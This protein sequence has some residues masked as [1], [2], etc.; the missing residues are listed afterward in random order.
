MQFTIILTV[1]NT[2][3]YLN[4]CLESID[5]QTYRDFE[6]LI[7]DDGSTDSSPEICDRFCKEKS[8][9]R[10]I[11]KDNEGLSSA[12]NLGIKESKGKYLV[13]ID[14]DDLIT[15]NAL[16][17]INQAMNGDEDIII[18]ELLNCFEFPSCDISQQLYNIPNCLSVDE[19]IDYVFHKENVQAAVQY[20]VKKEF[21]A[22]NKIHF[23][24]GYLHEDNVYTPWI[25]SCC[26][27]FSFCNSLWYLR[28]CNRKDSITNSL[29][30]KRV[31]DT[32]SLS[33]LYL[34]GD[35][36]SKSSN[37]AQR[38]IRKSIIGAMWYQLYSYIYFS[39]SEKKAIR[40]CLK[41]CDKVFYF[42][43]RLKHK[44][45]HYL[46]E[47]LGYNIGLTIIGNL[48]RLLK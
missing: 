5:Q 20:I 42:E 32:I 26:K 6:L 41:R 34:T 3:Q 46:C 25:F 1:Y 30:V 11:H 4:H 38:I 40:E 10:V 35:Y 19:M 47:V 8:Y 14:S 17:D 18:S 27:K 12:R 36:Y 7:I 21:I 33:Y 43:S 29:N 2:S 24:K 13:F 9:A 48:K 37:V 44:I 22:H 28:R 23:E 45:A 16:N 39:A 31:L 15:N